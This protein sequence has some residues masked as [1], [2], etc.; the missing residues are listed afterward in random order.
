[1]KRIIALLFLSLGIG[2]ISAQSTGYHFGGTLMQQA[3]LSPEQMVQLAQTQ[4]LGTSRSMAMAGAFA[5][6]GGD[7]ASMTINPAGLGMFRHNEFSLTPMITVSHSENSAPAY[8][9]N[10]KTRFT[11]SNFALVFNTFNG[12]G[13]VISIN[14]GVAYN[15]IAD[16]NY[17]TSFQYDSPFNGQQPSPSILNVMAGQLTANQ[18]YPDESGFLGYYGNSYPDLWGAMLAYN[19]YL[20]NPY[21]D[22]QG[23]YWEADRVGY[24]A[25][26]GHFYETESRGSIGEWDISFGMN[27]NNVVYIGATLGLQ[28]ISQRITTYYG[29]DYLYTNQYGDPVPAVNAN[30][31][32]LIEQA[33]FIHYDQQA[34]MSGIGINAKFG[35]IVR[36]IPALRIGA[37]IHSPNAYNIDHTYYASMSS[38]CYNND[39]E[40]YYSEDLDTNGNWDDVGEDSWRFR[41]P[42]RLMVGASYAFGTR[43][44]I[45]VDYE[46]NWYNGMRTKNTPWWIPDP[47]DYLRNGFRERFSATNTIRIGAEFKPISRLSLRAGAGYTSSLINQRAQ[48]ESFPLADQVVWYS[49]GLGFA[50]TPRTSLDIAYQYHKTQS[51]DYRLFYGSYLDADGSLTLFDAAEKVSTHQIRHHIALTMNF[52][53]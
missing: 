7:V 45:S 9:G 2:S 51:Q 41:T 23:D 43:G 3:P 10:S 36:P 1:M 39:E 21:T 20:I 13:K 52:R 40:R 4:P 8:A 6:L 26:V 49:G 38:V 30:G 19:S 12:L 44:I 11:P 14:V 35:I 29:E 24:N 37:A 32:E 16:L 17:R 50:I 28:Q 25:L 42:L 31:E 46:R 15:R 33:D 48:C 53:F 22:S 34:R 27:I 18:I 5:S 47:A